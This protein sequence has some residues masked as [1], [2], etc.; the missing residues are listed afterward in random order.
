MTTPIQRKIE[1]IEN[2][3]DFQSKYFEKNG[4]TVLDIF[5]E[6]VENVIAEGKT[7]SFDEAWQRVYD[8]AMGE[9]EEYEVCEIKLSTLIPLLDPVQHRTDL[10][11]YKQDTKKIEQKNISENSDSKHYKDLNLQSIAD[12]QNSEDFD[13]GQVVPIFFGVVESDA[14]S[15]VRT[16]DGRHRIAV[17]NAMGLEWIKA[18]LLPSQKLVLEERQVEVRN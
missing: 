7:Y 3:S 17:Y 14:E 16:S 15:L 10:V 4:D 11:S 13:E 1:G 12:I 9:A 18:E 5:R 8:L 2:W 6:H